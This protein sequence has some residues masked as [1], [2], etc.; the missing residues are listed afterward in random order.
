MPF[1]F[2]RAAAAAGTGATVP[3]DAEVR[4]DRLG[5]MDRSVAVVR[6]LKISRVGHAEKVVNVKD[7]GVFRVNGSMLRRS[8][9][10]RGDLNA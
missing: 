1:A 6:R 2:G 10:Q 5:P 7:R 8:S 4:V 3:L 9:I